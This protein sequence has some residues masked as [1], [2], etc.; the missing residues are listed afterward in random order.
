MESWSFY[1]LLLILGMIFEMADGEETI[2]T[3]IRD[4]TST[5][6]LNFPTIVFGGEEAPAIC[7][8]DNWV[9]CLSS[10]EYAEGM[11]SR[12][13]EELKLAGKGTIGKV[14]G[15]YKTDIRMGQLGHEIL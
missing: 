6:Q 13:E 14:G 7:Y 8:S 3:F 4:I 11:P 12:Y 5:F 2:S 9:H 10:D 1:G 15:Y